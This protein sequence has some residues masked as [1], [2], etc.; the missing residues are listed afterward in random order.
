[1]TMKKLLFASFLTLLPLLAFGQTK[2][3]VWTTL[4]PSPT[5]FGGGG[6]FASYYNS[7]QSP[8][9]A[10]DAECDSLWAVLKSTNSIAGLPIWQATEVQGAD[11]NSLKRGAYSIIENYQ[12]SPNAPAQY[13]V[14]QWAPVTIHVNSIDA[15]DT[16][17]VAVFTP[18]ANFAVTSVIVVGGNDTATYTSNADVDLG[19]ITYAE[20]VDGVAPPLGAAN[21]LTATL[22]SPRKIVPAGT[23]LWI[24]KASA[25]VSTTEH[26]SV[27]V[28]GNYLY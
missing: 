1:M 23:T 4:T 28:T 19:W 26:F 27:T 5:G 22:I 9:I 21:T 20:I 11:T 7:G 16:G 15:T 25:A 6:A 17:L 12:A 14:S 18:A 24:H 2:A 13:K 8:K 3:V 10:T